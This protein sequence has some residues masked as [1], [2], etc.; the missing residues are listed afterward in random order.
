MR[1]LLSILLTI[2]VAFSF[3]SCGE[4]KA[5]KTPVDVSA[6]SLK[7]PTSIGLINIID[8][9]EELNK[10]GYTTKIEVAASPDLIVPRLLKGELDIAAVPLNVGSKVYNAT[11]GQYKLAAINTLGVLYLLSS[12]ENVKTLEDLKGE[13]LYCGTPGATPDYVLQY[14]LKQKDFSENDIKIDYSM[15][16]P[17][18]AQALIGGKVKHAIMPEPFAT[19]VS[20]KNKNL[21]RFMDIQEEWRNLN[22]NSDIIM[23]ALL[24]KTELIEN[25]KDYVDAFLKE[26]A[27]SVEWANSNLKECGELLKKHEILPDSKIAE[28][29]VPRC[30]VVF[31]NASDKKDD[32]NAFLK[33]LFDFNKKS[34]GGK[35]PDEDF[36]M[37]K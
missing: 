15:K 37:E 1:K 13:T 24:I 18:L 2:A 29:S 30:N 27:A 31:F 16:T 36:F 35:L 34:V 11:K 23:G 17:E 8:G 9:S 33:I 19:I 3:V 26:Y 25:N 7:G 10:D 14:I 4:K 6:A 20:L 21:N 5:T 28:L 22:D 32:V 12:D